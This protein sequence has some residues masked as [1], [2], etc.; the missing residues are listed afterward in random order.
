MNTVLLI[1]LDTVALYAGIMVCLA[2]VRV[3]VCVVSFARSVYSD[4]HPVRPNPVQVLSEYIPI[5]E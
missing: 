1:G 3:C 5:R 4:S 2:A